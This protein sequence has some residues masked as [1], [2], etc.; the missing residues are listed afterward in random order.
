LIL[1]YKTII[2]AILRSYYRYGITFITLIFIAF[3]VFSQ[4][5][6]DSDI[7]LPEIIKTAK[8]DGVLKTKVEMSTD[9][10]VMR[11]NVRNA[12][13]GLRGDIGEYLNYR[14]QFEFSNEGRLMPLDLFGTLTPTKDLSFIL[15]QQIIPFENG[16][17]ITPSDAMFANRAFLGKY[18]T[19]FGRDIGAVVHY[20]FRIN[21]FPM[22]SQAG[23]FNGSGF[24]N[25]Q[26]TDKPAF[27]LRLLAGSM[28][29]FRA[30]TKAFKYKNVQN[31]CL[32]LGADVRYV[33]SRI[34][35]ETEVMNR[36]S[37]IT[38]SDLFGTYIQG[39][40]SFPLS[41]TKMFNLLTP[42]ARWDAMGY[43]VWNNGFD[44]NR[45]TAGVH[46][47]LTFIPFDSLLR[48]DYEHYLVKKDIHF[49]DFDRFGP[50]VSDNK[51]TVELLI[52]F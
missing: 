9:S 19:P 32:L 30:S 42:A 3:S 10:G 48:I 8:F 18:F 36:H 4:S 12:R 5:N 11:F 27:A 50:H 51:V 46:F 43:D 47:G 13:L 28:N 23:I 21:S 6:S 16:Y 38:D 35:V 25:P 39:A 26:W 49:P 31:D 7:A 20:R 29:G 14:F 1:K 41:I 22:E 24:N 37:Y 2:L 40:Y 15:G 17:I 33:N 45:L 44:V 52:K 34:R